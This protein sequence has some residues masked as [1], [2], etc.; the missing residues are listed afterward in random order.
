M[1]IFRRIANV[2][3]G[4]ANDAVDSMEKPEIVLNQGIRDLEEVQREAVSAVADSMA[5][6]KRLEML[7]KKAEDETAKWD[8][9]ARSA[10]TQG[11]EEL[12]L[13]CVQ[14][15]NAAAELVTQYQELL[16][17]QT[18]QVKVLRENL[19]EIERRITD[20]KRRKDTLIAKNKIAEAN[21][22]VTN[23]M[24]SAADNNIFETLDRMEEKIEKRSLRV[25][26]LKELGTDDLEK[27]LRDLN[28]H[29]AS[30]DLEALKREMGLT[31]GD[32]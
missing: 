17:D 16:E 30:A 5:E 1:G 23:V 7:L 9:G 26:A 25:D 32:A 2:F 31:K 24:S 29:N 4:M 18:E 28:K 11:N 13:K 27:Q 19:A 8:A 3:R 12:A 22:K 10:L 15:K 21:E 20:A 6:K 14:Q